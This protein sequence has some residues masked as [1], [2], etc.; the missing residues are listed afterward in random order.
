M[1]EFNLT[2]KRK[3]YT[4]IQ[5]RI[6]SWIKDYENNMLQDSNLL[7]KEIQKKQTHP[8]KKLELVIDR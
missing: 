8:L 5:N 7:L 1:M 3:Q 6:S 2:Y 4:F